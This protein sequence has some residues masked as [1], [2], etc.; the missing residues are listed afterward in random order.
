MVV[1]PIPVAMFA[2]GSGG[3]VIAS[4]TPPLPYKVAHHPEPEEAADEAGEGDGQVLGD[5]RL[6]PDTVDEGEDGEDEEDEYHGQGEGNECTVVDNAVRR[7]ARHSVRL[8]RALVQ[9]NDGSCLKGLKLL[10]W[11]D[12]DVLTL[13]TSE[14][15]IYNR[16]RCPT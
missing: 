7:R 1:P 3:G 16:H 2:S 4:A 10:D 6:D 14:P 12:G 11:R 8:L 9:I 15:L 5:G 13:P